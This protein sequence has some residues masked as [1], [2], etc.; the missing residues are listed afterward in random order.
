M[1]LL[2]INKLNYQLGNRNQYVKVDAEL[3]G[4]GV[5]LVQGPSGAGK[6][7]LLRLL[8]RLQE[9]GGGEALLQGKSWREYPPNRWR[10]LVHYLAQKPALF[11]GT[12][13][14]NLR[15]PFSTALLKAGAKF[16][17]DRAESLLEQMLLSKN[18]L[19][20]D[21]RIISGGEAARVALTRALLISPVVLLLDEPMAALDVK[22]HQAVQELLINWVKGRQDRGI[23][24]VSHVDDPSGWPGA[25]TFDIQ[26]ITLEGM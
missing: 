2:E 6:S 5:L 3:P 10:L 7:T 17:Q 16:D 24:L 8:A 22:T 23:V 18:I 26:P 14:E 11:E 15:L 1:A 19:A 12:V 4:G 25:L 9:A 20:Q 21:A 13:L